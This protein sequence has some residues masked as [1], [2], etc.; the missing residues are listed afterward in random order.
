MITRYA[1]FNGTVKSGQQAA[2]R[3]WVNTQLAP[4]WRQFASAEKV[5]ILFG[6]EQPDNGPQIPLL[7]AITYADHAA[8]QRGLD[9]PARYESRD[10]LPEFYARYFDDVQLHH[11][12]LEAA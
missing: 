3:D 12:V 6:V 5:E 8:M 7:L 10:L 1:I 4:L 2:M 11:Y 9:S